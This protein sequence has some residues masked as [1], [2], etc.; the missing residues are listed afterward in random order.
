MNLNP[1][2]A[3]AI[4]TL[5]LL[6]LFAGLRA[7]QVR[8]SPHPEWVRKLLHM[9]MGG[10]TLTF[11]WLFNETWPVVILASTTIIGLLVL[12]NRKAMRQQW[13]DVLHGVS[14][15]SLGEMYFPAAVALLFVLADG[16]ALLFVIPILILT[17]ADALAAL[18]GL[19]YGQTQYKTSEG[20]KSLEGSLAFFMVAFLSVHIPLLLFS[21]VGRV[22]S[23]LIALIMGGLVML[24]EAI[25]WRGLDNL[26]IPLGA[27][28]L[29]QTY[30]PMGIDLLTLKLS[31][32]LLLLIGF[33]LIRRKTTLDDSA[34]LGLV[35]IAY[36]TWSVE[37]WQWLLAPFTVF[38]AYVLFNLSANIRMERAHSIQA[39]VCVGVPSLII[40]FLAEGLN[41]PQLFYCYTLAYAVQL[42]LIGVA[43]IKFNHTE[44]N[45]TRILLQAS[46]QG[47]TLLLVPWVIMT[48]TFSAIYYALIA[49]VLIFLSAC[50]FFRW[51]PQIQDCPT[52]N[53][54]WW[55]QGALAVSAALIGSVPLYLLGGL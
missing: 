37:G 9:I 43:R 33:Y 15:N 16:N 3:M 6:V 27:F 21:D 46:F 40:L 2:L 20:N 35:L 17:L 48:L 44:L 42:T 23:L 5:A 18:I 26:F 54:R 51:Q 52:D 47:W 29:L 28:V 12:K 4:V 22:E 25:A 34:I 39:V 49:A 1:W 19:R 8:Y 30:L 55:R 31:V 36:V 50:L 41:Q 24:F 7:Y 14:R 10:V 13:G 38:I 32:L 45:T 53:S 11:P